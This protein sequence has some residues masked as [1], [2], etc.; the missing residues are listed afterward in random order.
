MNYLKTFE[1]FNFSDYFLKHKWEQLGIEHRRE[2][3]QE[4]WELV[5][6]AYQP[7]G[8]HVRINNPDSVI[9][10]KDLDFWKGI[11][12]D[13]D[14]KADVVFFSRKSFGNK[15]SGW[16]HDG[17]KEAR[18]KLMEK[19]AAM[20]NTD[21]FWVEVSGRPAEILI[22]SGCDYVNDPKKIQSIFKDSKINWKGHGVYTRTLPD[23]VET[24]EEY[25]IGKP[26]FN[27]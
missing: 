5:D 7:L 12:I 21:G 13:S 26:L 25:I 4:L 17:S 1:K 20:L 15:I 19:L 2:L 24:D 16:G 3:K 23:G 14:P 9:N 10:D 27:S 11:D 18:K 6:L 22:N 8:G